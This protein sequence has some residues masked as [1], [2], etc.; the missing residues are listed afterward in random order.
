[1]IKIPYSQKRLNSH[2]KQGKYSIL[3]G[4]ILII[5]FTVYNGPGAFYGNSAG[6]GL[7]GGSLFTFG[8]YFYEKEK[9]YLTFKNGLLIKNNLFAKKIVLD[10]VIQIKKYAG[11][12]ILLTDKKKFVIDTQLIDHPSIEVLENEL[13]KIKENPG[14][15]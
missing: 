2:F 5:I 8:I 6:I 3:I 4:V 1:M 14:S 10:R 11:D 9:H 13:E 15:F 7:I 12:Y